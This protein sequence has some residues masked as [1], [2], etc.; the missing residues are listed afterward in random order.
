[1]EN[2]TTEELHH[3]IKASTDIEDYLKTN[4]NY[5]I[6]DTLPDYLNRMLSQ[7]GLNRADVVRRSLLDRVY[8]YQIFSGRRTPSRD[9]LI[10]MAFGL[11]LSSEETQKMLKL[12]CNRELYARDE[13]D[14]LIL[15][16]LNRE[17]TIMEANELLF[18]HGFAALGV[19]AE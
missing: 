9:K 5:M 13:R 10:S 11:C 17:Q 19:L 18:S 2:K 1:M 3:E 15:F 14:A 7:K 6:A 16:A 4:Q 12:S 8:V